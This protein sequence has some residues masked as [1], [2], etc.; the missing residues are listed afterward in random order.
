MVFILCVYLQMIQS[1]LGDVRF[2]C[3]SVNDTGFCAMKDND[4]LSVL[5]IAVTPYVQQLGSCDPMLLV[6]K[7]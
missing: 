6:I 5:W 7:P 1:I 2:R 3:W 4:N